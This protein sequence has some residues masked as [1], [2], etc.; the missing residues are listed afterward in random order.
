MATFAVTENDIVVNTIIADTKEIAEMVTDKT[1]I[2]Y[3]EKNSA[4]IG[5]VYD[6]KSFI[7]PK[8]VVEAPTKPTE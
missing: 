1:C 6:G 8:P 4:G 5:Y 7:Q 2:E 3:T